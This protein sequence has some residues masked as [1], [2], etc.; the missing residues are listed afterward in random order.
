MGGCPRRRFAS[1]P[2]PRPGQHAGA[3]PCMLTLSFL[4]KTCDS[5]G[6]A[7]GNCSSP[8]QEFPVHRHLSPP[9][10]SCKPL[11]PVLAFDSSRICFAA[12][13]VAL[14]LAACLGVTDYAMPW[15]GAFLFP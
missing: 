1:F 13:S 5:A 11:V 14:V 10:R 3:L 9:S 2:P 8:G 12:L 6:R 4:V 7:T 15:A